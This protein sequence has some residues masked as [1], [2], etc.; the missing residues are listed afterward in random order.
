LVQYIFNLSCP[1]QGTPVAGGSSDENIFTNC[2]EPFRGQ[3][4]VRWKLTPDRRNVIVQMMGKIQNARGANSEYMSFG[5]SGT[6]GR[7]S[8]IG[9][10]VVVAYYDQVKD[11]FTVDDYYLG[12]KYVS[13]FEQ[14]IL[15]INDRKFASL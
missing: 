15:P 2:I 7:A 13:Y 1:S 6:P 11:S 9:G 12:S 8:M 4:Q 3:M 10:D 5:L 14:M